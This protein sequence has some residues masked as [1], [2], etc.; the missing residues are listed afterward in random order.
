MLRLAIVAM[1]GRSRGN[2]V[3]TAWTH[4]VISYVRSQAHSGGGQGLQ[5]FEETVRRILLVISAAN[6]LRCETD[7]IVMLLF[8]IARSAMVSVPGDQ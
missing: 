4:R 5:E 8:T 3:E 1:G 7:L 6:I 2:G